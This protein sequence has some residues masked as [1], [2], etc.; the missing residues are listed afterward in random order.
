MVGTLVGI[1]DGLWAIM[2]MGMAAAMVDTMVG[3]RD[4]KLGKSIV[5][6]LQRH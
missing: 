4:G 5:E 6:F 1:L 3:T 2:G